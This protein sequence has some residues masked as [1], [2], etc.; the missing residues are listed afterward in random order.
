LAPGL[1]ARPRLLVPIQ[2]RWSRR[3]TAVV[4]GAGFGKTT[5]LVQAMH[6]NALVPQGVDVWL[7]LDA[8][9]ASATRLGAGLLRA[10]DST[11]AVPSGLAALTDAISDAVWSRAPDEVCLVLD[12]VHEVPPDSTGEDL[13]IRL[14]RVL[15][16]N[17]HVL[18]ASRRP[19]PLDVARLAGQ[20][21]AIVLR[22]DDLRL[23]DA[24]VDQFAEARAVA[25]SALARADGWPALTE[26]VAGAY[27]VS[28]ADFLSE[29]LLA[30]LEPKQRDRMVEVAALGGADSAILSAV[31]GTDVDL[32]ELLADVPLARRSGTGWWELHALV[33]DA[34]LTFA[35][36]ETVAAIRRRGAELMLDRGDVNRAVRLF[37]AAG[38]WGELLS[39]LRQVVIR[40][41]ARHEP[42]LLASWS[43]LFPE[44]IAEEPEVLL[45]RAVGAST[46]DTDQAFQQAERAAA[47]F[48]ARD[49]VEGEVAALAQVGTIAFASND[50]PRFA[51]FVGRVAELAASGTPSAVA[52]DHVVRGGIAVL[53]GDPDLAIETLAPVVAAP[54]S[55]PTEGASAYFYTRALMQVGRWIDAAAVLDGMPASH[56]ATFDGV[57]VMRS[58]LA[59]ARGRPDLAHRWLAEL[60]AIRGVLPAMEL[61]KSYANNALLRSF[62]GD[63]DG[64][65]ADLAALA[66]SGPVPEG[67]VAMVE[68]AEVALL[69]AR[70]DDDRAAEVLAASPVLDAHRM[71]AETFAL[72]YVLAPSL[73]AALDSRSYGETIAAQQARAHALVAAREGT[74]LSLVASLDWPAEYSPGATGLPEPWELEL[75][76][77]ARA[78]GRDPTPGLIDLIGPRHRATVQR[79]AKSPDGAVAKVATELLATLPPASPGR[80]VV[81]VLGPLEVWVDD[82]RSDA[83][84]LRRERVRALLGILVVRGRVRR[85]EVADLL[86]PEL[87]RDAAAANLRVT[88]GHLLRVL[89]PARSKG[90]PS[91]FVRN[92]GELLALTDEVDLQIDV[93]DFSAL[94]DEATRLDSAGTPSLALDAYRDAAALYRD[95]LLEGVAP[96]EWIDFER[97]RLRSLFGRSAV[98]AGELLVA[99]GEPDAAVALA[100]RAIAADRWTEPAYRL[101][102]LAELALGNRTAALR[103]LGHMDELLEE[104]GVEPEPATTALRM[105]CREAATEP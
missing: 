25:P 4:A 21:R 24:E 68:R 104:L 52:F 99:A 50:I 48:A 18:A 58:K 84:E 7:A 2:G 38:A 76:V 11:G 41:G 43:H 59:I 12:D 23:T 82:V 72:V 81:N 56:R 67:I 93:R 66:A 101:L 28:P 34:L 39:V 90:A 95:E 49:D 89:E 29:Q 96:A 20:R 16:S 51:P 86:W 37:A 32:A 97:L 77:C 10:L 71:P 85:E 92:H 45:V 3:V 98:R 17:A 15:P 78:A 47:A 103:V 31:A 42:G 53:S 87:D 73:R 44:E 8:G 63:L 75:S 79:L 57:L 100:E 6:E 35:T 69:A 19:L 91:F 61:R 22:E 88:L 46:D 60:D 26:L 30:G 1:L 83:P 14:A 40:V 74:D 55:D 33:T 65:A 5:L 105:R 64:A 36:P 80:V 62:L 94:V 54:E 27:G 102:A 9:D 70:G 13:L